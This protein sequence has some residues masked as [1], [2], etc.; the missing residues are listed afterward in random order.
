MYTA[1]VIDDDAIIVDALCL[2]IPWDEL[3]VSHVERIYTSA[4]LAERIIK[5]N[6]YL[7]FIDIELDV[8]SGLDVLSQCRKHGSQ[9]IFVIVSAHDDFHYAHSAINLGA[10]Y[11]LL[12]PIIPSDISVLT[13][14]IK[15]IL[16]TP[17]E[18]ISEHLTSSSEFKNYLLANFES[19]TSYRF[20][21]CSLNAPLLKELRVFL[22]PTLIKQYKMGTNRFL[23]ILL[24]QQLDANTLNMLNKFAVDN[25][26][27]LGLSA[28]FTKTK[29]FFDFFR[30]A[31][32]LSYQDFITQAGGLVQP[33]EIALD[34]FYK[35]LDSLNTSIESQS[36]ENLIQIFNDLPSVFFDNN[37]TMFHVLLLYHALMNKINALYEQNIFPNYQM[38]EEDI[39]IYSR[40][41]T[42][43][44]NEL[45]ENINSLFSASRTGNAIMGS[46]AWNRIEAYLNENYSRKL[47]APEVANALYISTT[48]LY[49]SIKQNTGNTFIEYLTLRRIKKA[50]ELLIETSMSIT[51][52]AESIGIRDIFYFS[53]VFKKET[54]MGATAF[55]KF[56]QSQ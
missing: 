52:I 48:T 38:R 32:T 37:Y 7:V 14:K 1:F 4:G 40:T 3:Q 54:G 27:C 10:M 11:Y 25:T 18:D 44:C 42:E 8:S 33:A 20:L 46:S 19:D 9:S 50:K 17:K 29:R 2:Q 41:F 5:E 39:V 24:N 56:H 12:K 36:S 53:K 31:N 49:N 13:E 16:K 51:D 55:R 45:S 22:T 30:E 26:L 35:I 23:F 21:V 28:P 34:S 15:H 6:P 47:S 43:L